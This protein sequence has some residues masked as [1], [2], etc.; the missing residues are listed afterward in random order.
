MDIH[1]DSVNK[2]ISVAIM[3]VLV[4]LVQIGLHLKEEALEVSSEQEVSAR[5]AGREGVF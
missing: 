3:V 4:V 5:C 1:L 2:T